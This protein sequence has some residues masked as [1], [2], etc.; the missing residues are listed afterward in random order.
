MRI[1]FIVGEFPLLSETFIIDRITGLLD[2]GHDVEIFG[3]R[4]AGG[5]CMHA[6]VERYRL[7]ERTTY[8]PR[9]QERRV[10]RYL[11]GLGLL[12]TRG[13]HHPRRALRALDLVRYGRHAASLSMLHAAA[14]LLHGP[15][16]DVVHCHF[17]PVAVR[18]ALLH[19]A[20][21]VRGRL[22]ASFY[23]HDVTRYPRERGRNVYRHLFDRV[24]VVLALSEHMRRQ[25]V[26]LGCDAAKVRVHRLGVD[27]ERFRPVARATASGSPFRV[28][29]IGRLVEKKGFGDALRAVA[30]L[31]DGGVVVRFDLVG[32][33]PLGSSLRSLA[34]QLGLDEQVR[35]HGAR[36][37]RDVQA[38]LA[39]ADVLLAPSVTAADGDT[40]GIPTVIQ[41]AMACAVPVVST[42]HSGIPELIEDGV[43]GILADEGDV[44]VLAAA[45]QRLADDARFR[46]TMGAAGR[47]CVE[48]SFN[49]ERQ[50]D[51]LCMM[52][53]DGETEGTE[54]LRH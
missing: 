39:D 46:R 25:L 18:G 38:L 8:Q 2:R 36:T 17:G 41:E 16:Y 26:D 54:G 6:S 45:L 44:A 28:L 53:R 4:P 40:E 49:L 42:R 10:P 20:G 43:S 31:R 50:L 34:R 47:A 12:A 37:A 51:E 35:W 27:C 21:I 30:H 15:A 7:L 23:G 14:P 32:D 3:Q 24:E 29:G 13:V 48:Q 9:F 33:G 19:D 5:G 1:A 11:R 52:Y 22:V